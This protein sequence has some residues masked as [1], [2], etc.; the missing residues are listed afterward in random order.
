MLINWDQ[1][2]INV[3]P[4]SNYTME[5]RGAG[6]VEIA[7]YGDKGMITAT[8]AATLSGKFLPMQILYGGKTE[9]CHPRHTFPAEFDIHHNPSHWSNE[10]CAIR[11]IEKIILPYVITT[12]ERL[13][14]PS[15]TAMVI[16]DVFKGQTTAAVFNLLEE[17]N[18]VYEHIP[19]GCTDKLQPLDLSVN[20]SAKSYL[21]EKFSTWYAEQ[22][23]QQLNAGKQATDVQV[24]MRLSVMKELSAKWLDSLYDHLRASTQ[25]IIN[26]FKEAGILGAFESPAIPTDPDA[27]GD[28]FAECV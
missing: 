4:T 16:F 5:E 28:P 14:D 27:D 20:K 15:Q 2:G 9:R 11:F 22:V 8:F 24:D 10:E 1:T 25:L 7:G 12:R 13:N 18:I 21:R 3:V 6:R 26:G 19:N 23:K 17:S